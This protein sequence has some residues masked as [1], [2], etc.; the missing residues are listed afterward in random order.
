[1]SDICVKRNIECLHSKL[2]LSSNVLNCGLMDPKTL[3]SLAS[4]IL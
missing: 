3:H 4:L 2:L 1:M